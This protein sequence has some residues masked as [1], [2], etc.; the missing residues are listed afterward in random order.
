MFF[1]P[2]HSIEE[3]EFRLSFSKALTFPL[4]IHRSFEF[5]AQTDGAADVTVG[6]RTYRLSAGDAVLI[7]PFQVHEIGRAHV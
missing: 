6:D 1:E 2:K 3:N 5:Y 7:F 4:H